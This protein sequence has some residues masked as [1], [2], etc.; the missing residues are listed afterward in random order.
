MSFRICILA[1]ALAAAAGARAAADEPLPPP[2][3]APPEPPPIVIYRVS[4]Y[5]VWQHLAVDQQGRF[6]PRVVWAPY[7][8]FYTYSGK[9]YPWLTSDPRRFMPYVT[10]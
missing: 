10:D 7:G 8:A 2:R 6:R 1:V 4:Q 9:P 5:E 3:I